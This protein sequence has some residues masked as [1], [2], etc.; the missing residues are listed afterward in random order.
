MVELLYKQMKEL[1]P[2]S[3]YAGTAGSEWPMQYGA[4]VEFGKLGL[5]RTLRLHD[6]PYV[7][8]RTPF[9][10][11]NN[12]A[13]VCKNGFCSSPCDFY[14]PV[15]ARMTLKKKAVGESVFRSIDYWYQGNLV[16]SRF[17]GELSFGRALINEKINVGD[18]YL[19][20]AE[21]SNPALT[22]KTII[23]EAK[24]LMI[25]L[26]PVS[27]PTSGAGRPNGL[28]GL[29]I[30]Q[31]TNI[32]PMNPGLLGLGTIREQQNTTDS[33]IYVLNSLIGTDDSW[34]PYYTSVINGDLTDNP[35]RIYQT[36][37]VGFRVSSI[38]STGSVGLDHVQYSKES[39][40][41]GNY[42][43]PVTAPPQIKCSL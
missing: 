15:A 36:L 28:E 23:D 8:L 27:I 3:R 24:Q 41:F 2:V 31:G 4:Q 17:L 35:N 42:Q 10:V 9:L 26:A 7:F 19:V 20:V 11:N 14:A 33:F 29:G 25:K 16:P 38:S 37:K 21:F 22:Y 34:P 30:L 5:S 6:T 13:E 43:I 12:C 39:K 1:M 32:V 18:M 40:I